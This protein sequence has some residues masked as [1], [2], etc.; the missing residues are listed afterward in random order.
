MEVPPM[1]AAPTPKSA[2]A[3]A[4]TN[5]MRRRWLL[6]LDDC[7]RAEIA[8]ILE[9][10]AAMKELLGRSIKQAPVLR[11][12]NVAT[13]FFRADA[14]TRLSFELAARSLS[15]NVI[16]ADEQGLQRDETLPSIARTLHA[17]GVDIL[18]VR[19]DEAGAPYLI[20]Q[21]FQGALING[22]DGQHA[23]PTQALAHLFTIQ[24]KLS[25]LDHLKVVIV[26]D[27]LHS[28]VARSLLWGLGTMGAQIVLCAPHTLLGPAAFW[29]AVWPELT[30][31]TDL[32]ECLTKADAV[33][34]LPLRNERLQTGLLP[35][36]RE[37]GRFFGLT[38]ERLQRAAPHCLVLHHGPVREGVEMTPDVIAT[39][40]AASADQITNGVAVRMALLYRLAGG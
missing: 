22:G 6:D 9:T 15:A 17:L 33:I 10:A 40:Q 24:Q 14:Q 19:H 36:P 8:D 21:H 5:G 38:T 11:G 28:A 31:S 30:I 1:S 39:I 35:S 16:A 32:E 25:W 29:K 4:A 34:S 18:I 3:A 20:A 37:Y 7:A 12:M 2:K 23:H 13:L 27:V 26:G